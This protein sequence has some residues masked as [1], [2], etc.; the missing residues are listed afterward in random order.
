MHVAELVLLAIGAAL[1]LLSA[2]GLLLVDEPFVRLHFLSPSSTL[3]APLVCLAVMLD[4]GHSRTT[5]KVGV[6]AF[7]IVMAQPAVTATTG[8]AIAV[9]R[10]LIGVP[11]EVSPA[12]ADAEDAG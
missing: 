6:I 8:R 11:N 5:A 10:G 4:Q 12:H 9:A 3:G 2:V 1:V 7:L